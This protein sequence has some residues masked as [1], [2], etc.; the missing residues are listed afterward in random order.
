MNIPRNFALPFDYIG[1][2]LFFALF[3]FSAFIGSVLLCIA[4]ACAF[5]AFVASIYYRQLED[6][7]FRDKGVFLT[8]KW[9]TILSTALFATALVSVVLA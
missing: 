1:A 2:A 6:R 9:L 7:G 5:M 4:C 3:G 8:C